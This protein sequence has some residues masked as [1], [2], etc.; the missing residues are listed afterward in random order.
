MAERWWA[1]RWH[2]LRVVVGMPAW[3]L[4]ALCDGLSAFRRDFSDTWSQRWRASDRQEAQRGF[5]AA[6]KG[7]GR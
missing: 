3:L 2:V 5:G 7:E 4:A 1:I 6:R